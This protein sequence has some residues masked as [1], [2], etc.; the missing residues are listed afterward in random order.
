[1]TTWV[2][3]AENARRAIAAT[4]VMFGGS[5]DD[6]SDADL[7]PLLID[8]PSSTVS[9]LE[10]ENGVGVLD[11]L[12]KTGLAKSKGAARRTLQQGGVYVNNRRLTE[13]R[14]LSTQDLGTET[15]LVLR[16]GKKDYHIVR[17]G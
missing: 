6:L 7:E 11:L 3:G 5:L 8:V 13:E 10:L 1:M 14:S 16:M 4:H 17:V 15:M 12:A 9:R 2:H